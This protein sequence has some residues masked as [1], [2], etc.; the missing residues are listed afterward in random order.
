MG[1]WVLL[2][3]LKYRAGIKRCP[4]ETL[5]GTPLSPRALPGRQGTS[6]PR[7]SRALNFHHLSGPPAGVIR[8]HL[9]KS[10]SSRPAARWAP[11]PARP[12]FP[13]SRRNAKAYFSPS[14]LPP[15]HTSPAALAPDKGNRKSGGWGRLFRP[16]AARWSVSTEPAACLGLQ[17][18]LWEACVV[19]MAKIRGLW[20]GSGWGREAFLAAL[21]FLNL[22]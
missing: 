7:G 11:P 16:I 5:Q 12:P 3:P 20:V 1:L 2:G 17:P 22:G 18:G 4:T 21:L 19:F 6:D 9:L 10:S 14:R 15:S 13:P 8:K